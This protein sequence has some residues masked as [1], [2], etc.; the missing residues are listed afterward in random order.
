MSLVG[1]VC[2][3]TQINF[4]SRGNDWRGVAGCLLNGVTSYT[5]ETLP[6]EGG[7]WSSSVVV[8]VG[9]IWL[10]LLVVV[11]WYLPASPSTF[12]PCAL[13]LLLAAK[14]ASRGERGASRVSA[15]ILQMPSS[16]VLPYFFSDTNLSNHKTRLCVPP[17]TTTTTPASLSRRATAVREDEVG[18][19]LSSIPAVSSSKVVRGHAA[20]FAIMLLD[21]STRCV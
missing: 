11:I 12:E 14:S 19:D 2:V 7:A 21:L 5:H 6:S 10:L 17:F 13:S 15:Y 9:G 20:S 3:S 18:S 16:S 1:V 4:S 8:Q